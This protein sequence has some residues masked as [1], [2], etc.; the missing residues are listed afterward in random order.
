MLGSGEV[1]AISASS[2]EDTLALTAF[3]AGTAHLLRAKEPLPAGRLVTKEVPPDPQLQPALVLN[4][5]FIYQLDDVERARRIGAVFGDPD[6]FLITN[7][8]QEEWN[9]TF[10]AKDRNPPNSSAL[11]KYDLGHKLSLSTQ[12]LSGG[13]R[14][15][16]MCACAIEPN[17]DL[18]VVDLT[19][20]NLDREF[21]E[22]LTAMIVGSRASRV[23]ILIGFDPA[24]V[25]SEVPIR[26]FLLEN[27]SLVERAPCQSEFPPRQKAREDLT[28]RFRARR[29]GAKLLSIRGLYL[30]N[31]RKHAAPITRPVTFDLA[32][33][34]LVLITGPNGCGK[35]TLA[36]ILC[37]RVPRRY[38]GGHVIP[39]LSSLKAAMSL[40]FPERGFFAATVYDE[41]PC[42]ELLSLC[43]FDDSEARRDPRH[44]SPGSKKLL[45][46]A[47]TLQYSTDLAI[48]DEPTAGMDHVQKQRFVDLLNHFSERTVVVVTHDDAILDIGRVLRWKDIS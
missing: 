29:P 13:E 35:T 34:E 2:S 33:R 42:P 8:V 21:L 26:Q 9:Y 15:R 6:L 46:V 22:E 24:L 10:R 47:S 1:V 16:L 12:T 23:T 25:P 32:E 17:P 48:L 4:D 40:Q 36:R 45:A 37:N 28:R 41:L 44:L 14:Y 20:A 39:E 5:L 3:F 27:R 30:R 38:I 31:R 11:S 43:G 18:L 19:P 7:T